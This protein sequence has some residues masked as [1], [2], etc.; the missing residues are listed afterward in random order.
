MSPRVRR[1][2]LL[3]AGVIAL[4]VVGVLVSSNIPEEAS[5]PLFLLAIVV[6]VIV[7]PIPGGVIG[8]LG[9]ARFGFLTAWPLLYIGNVVGTT[10]LFLLVR[11]F[12][13]PIFEENVAEETRDRYQAIL[14]ERPFL[15]WFF[16]AV[17]MIPVDILSAM[18]G[19]SR[20][21]ARRFLLT[22]YSG[23]VLYTAII[24]FVGA[25][26]ADFIGVAGAISVIGAVFFLIIAVGLW[27]RRRERRSA[28]GSER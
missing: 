8:Y 9:A 19:L 12:G 10:I 25:F 21:S 28:I 26:L 18:A 16:Y 17:P 3:A 4:V 14:E 1:L 2:L 15:L 27:R 6:E 13:A 11:H 5:A 7:A 20:I 23:F 24:A 22:V